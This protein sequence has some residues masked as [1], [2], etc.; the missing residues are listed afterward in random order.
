[1]TTLYDVERSVSDARRRVGFE[2]E[3]PAEGLFDSV[4]LA[5][6]VLA[7]I[8]LPWWVVRFVFRVKD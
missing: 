2:A 1:M 4:G 5:I 6:V 3:P 7:V 8:A